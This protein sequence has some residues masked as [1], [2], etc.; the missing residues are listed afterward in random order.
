MLV[1]LVSLHKLGIAHN[2]IKLPNCLYDTTT[3]TVCLI[4]FGLAEF[5]PPGSFWIS[6]KV[7]T[8]AYQPPEVTKLQQVNHKVDVWRLGVMLVEIV[9]I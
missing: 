9:Y 6:D 5:H 8:R 3:G 7:G 4:D 1:A 2:D